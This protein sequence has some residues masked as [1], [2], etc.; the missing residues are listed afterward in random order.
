MHKLLA[1]QLRNA[2]TPDGGVD[3]DAFV[4]VIR[5]T[6]EEFDR[7]RR[8]TDRANRLMEEELQE[9]NEE[10]RR[11][12]E[13]R[14]SEMLDSMPCPVMLLTPS[15]EIQSANTAMMALCMS[16][17]RPL[18]MGE[19]FND[20][21]SV[22]VTRTDAAEPSSD[23]LAGKTIE[24]DILGRW[25]LASGIRFSDGS[26]VITLSDVTV[27]KERETVLGLAKDAAESANQLK[28]QFLAT[29]SHELR[30][31]LNAILGFSEM[32]S[33]RLLGDTP[34]ALHRYV[35]YA[36][37]I[38]S[39]GH[40]LLSLISEVLDLTKIDAG[41]YQLNIE[42]C[43]IAAVIKDALMLVRPQAER[44]SV[45][46]RPVQL[47][48]DCLVP[49]DRRAVKQVLA[50]LLANA[51]KFTP[52]GGEVEI[53]GR[54]LDG[55]MIV[56]VRD[57]GIGIAQEHQDTIFEPFRQGDAKVARSYEGTG[58]GLSIV[59][60]L[61]E[62]HGGKVWLQSVLGS[63]TTVTFSIPCAVSLPRSGVA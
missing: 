20:L 31:P 53:S 40:H 9:A 8:L 38:H 27:L 55:N 24:F 42:S 23:L 11:L 35:D 12:A 32:I 44:G 15:N 21:L 48:G 49:A 25:Y 5:R 22:L 28:S 18:I 2:T 30:T 50:N 6:Y 10:V 7:E 56:E 3:V 62:M 45:T 54:T 37:Q 39:S 1:H 58:L 19:S 16:L 59:R 63:G 46:L 51:V 43:D 4:A 34:E 41:A 17:H 33:S 14:M 52:A 61:V 26:R 29:M 47:D 36:T 60:G 13:L 57:T